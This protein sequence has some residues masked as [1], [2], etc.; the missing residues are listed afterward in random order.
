MIIGL[1]NMGIGLLSMRT[2][3]WLL[4][5]HSCIKVKFLSNFR[6]HFRDKDVVGLLT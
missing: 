1:L 6:L 4:V 2:F 3:N 5:G